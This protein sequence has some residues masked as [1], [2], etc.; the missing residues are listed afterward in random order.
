M[1]ETYTAL[2]DFLLPTFLDVV[3]EVTR[4]PEFSMYNLSRRTTDSSPLL[5]AS[6]LPFPA[7]STTAVPYE[8][9]SSRRRAAKVPQVQSGTSRTPPTAPP[10]TTTSQKKKAANSNSPMIAEPVPCQ[11][12]V[13][14]RSPASRPKRSEGVPT[15]VPASASLK[16]DSKNNRA[17]SADDGKKRTPFEKK[18]DNSGVVLERLRNLEN[19]QK[20]AAVMLGR[21]GATLV[22]PTIGLDKLVSKRCSAGL[23]NGKNGLELRRGSVL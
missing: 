3:R 1:L 12:S 14:P 15:N 16:K 23:E 21:K 13:P 20:S 19:R 18:S 6:S 17:T 8:P 11:K 4:N 7:P 2:A 10:S 9:G 5:T 22:I